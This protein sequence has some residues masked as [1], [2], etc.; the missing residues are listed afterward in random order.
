MVKLYIFITGSLQRG[1]TY[2]ECPFLDAIVQ[3]CSITGTG[4]TSHTIPHQRGGERTHNGEKE[5]THSTVRPETEKQ[6]AETRTEY[7]SFFV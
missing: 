2:L 4:G 3:N 1:V 7:I 5:R 6:V